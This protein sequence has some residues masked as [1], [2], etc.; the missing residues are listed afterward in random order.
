M[1]PKFENRNNLDIL[2]KEDATIRDRLDEYTPSIADFRDCYPVPK[3]ESDQ[4]K[5]DRMK[6]YWTKQNRLTTADK[7]EYV[8]FENLELGDWF[9]D[10]QGDEDIIDYDYEQDPQINSL[11]TYKTSEYDDYLNHTDMVV[12]VCNTMTDN[13][14]L[15][16]GIDVTYN[17]D[18]TNLKKKLGWQ[19]KETGLKG[20]TQ[21][22]YLDAHDGA[23][24]KGRIDIMPRL[25]IGVNPS[26][27]VDL[28]SITYRKN[29]MGGI[30][31]AEE[32][33]GANLETSLRFKIV[34]QIYTQIEDISDY[35]ENNTSEDSS[36]LIAEAKDQISK[37]K[38]YLK[39]SNQ[40]AKENYIKTFGLSG[41]RDFTAEA[42]LAHSAAT[43]HER[44]DTQKP[45]FS[46]RASQKIIDISSKMKS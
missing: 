11:A 26:E 46:Q 7:L 43:Y 3:L 34:N 22:D 25:V 20:F 9:G 41:A 36:E 35:L 6:E 12:S 23:K 44:N 21:L 8:I 18:D 24:I 31:E 13:K 19:H 37:L 42:I 17:K 38:K 28:S 10:Y 40:K 2:S 15:L 1:Q 4:A 30:S 33:E 39:Q 16:F 32:K 45:A 5:I 29:N 14:P 27:V